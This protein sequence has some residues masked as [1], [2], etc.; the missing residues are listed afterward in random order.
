MLDMQ[1]RSSR[2]AGDMK[3]NQKEVLPHLFLFIIKCMAL[4][5]R[6]NADFSTSRIR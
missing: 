2:I 1:E 5:L 6:F 3:G 4:F